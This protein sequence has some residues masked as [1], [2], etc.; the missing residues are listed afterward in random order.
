[1]QTYANTCNEDKNEGSRTF[2][3]SIDSVLTMDSRPRQAKPAE[4]PCKWEGGTCTAQDMTHAILPTSADTR[5]RAL[6]EVCVDENV[7]LPV[8]LQNLHLCGQLLHSVCLEQAT[9]RSTS[10]QAGPQQT[11]PCHLRPAV[12]GE[13][14]GQAKPGQLLLHINMFCLTN[15][16][17]TKACRP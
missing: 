16:H 6:A 10:A 3:L 7:S 13:V 11:D 4:S 2:L 14:L 5:M 17:T 8:L 12:A 1:M 9:E 15:A